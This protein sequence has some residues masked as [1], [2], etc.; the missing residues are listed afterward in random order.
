VIYEADEDADWTDPKVWEAANPNYGRSVSHDYLE[1][2]FKRATRTPAFENSFK[3]L[4]L[5]QWTES[6]SRWISSEDWRSCEGRVDTTP[7][8]PTFIGIDLASVTDL[9]AVVAIHKQSDEYHVQPYFFCPSATVQNAPK[10]HQAAYRQWVNDGYITVTEGSA[11]DYGQVRVLLEQLCTSPRRS[12]YCRRPL[13]G[14]RHAELVRGKRDACHE[15]ES[16]IRRTM[17][18]CQGS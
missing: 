6:E 14:P 18:W 12:L 9:T 10:R 16:N 3:N 11:T 4:H 13:A 17:A 1:D 7:G 5:N 8:A 15:G 2:A